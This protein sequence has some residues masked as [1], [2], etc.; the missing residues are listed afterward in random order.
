L[1]SF[2]IYFRKYHNIYDIKENHYT[3]ALDSFISYFEKYWN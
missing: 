1:Y 2:E 3:F